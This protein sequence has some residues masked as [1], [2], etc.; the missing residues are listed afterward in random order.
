MPLRA[1]ASPSAPVEETSLTVTR[2]AGNTYYQGVVE[3]FD[4]TTAEFSANSNGVLS[5][6]VKPNGNFS[7]LWKIY[8][9]LPGNGPLREGTYDGVKPYLYVPTGGDLDPYK[10]EVRFS[11]RRSDWEPTDAVVS[12]TI[13]KA[14]RPTLGTFG[15]HA[16]VEL[17]PSPGAPAVR[18]E[19]KYHAELAGPSVNLPPGVY[20]GPDRVAYPNQP[21]V[22]D[23]LVFDD[24]L[25]VDG[26]RQYHWTIVQQGGNY[27]LS[28]SRVAAPT[29]RLLDR[30]AYTFQLEVSDGEYSRKDTIKITVVDVEG[31]WQGFLEV[32]AATDTQGWLQVTGAPAG[33]FTGTL[34][35]LNLRVSFKGTFDAMGAATLP[36]KLGTFDGTLV[37]R[38]GT[39]GGL[40]AELHT[41]NGYFTAG[42]LTITARRGDMGTVPA[43]SF[44]LIFRASSGEADAFS[45]A[46]GRLTYHK[47]RTASLV[48]VLPDGSRASGSSALTK[49]NTVTGLLLTSGSR[50]WLGVDLF[51]SAF[52][53]I[54]LM[55][56]TAHWVRQLG[57]PGQ[58]REYDLDIYGTPSV[59]VSS[60]R[61][62]L[63]GKRTAYHTTLSL[64]AAD[65][66]YSFRTTT[67][68]GGFVTGIKPEDR[69]VFTGAGG[70]I[71]TIYTPSDAVA[72]LSIGSSGVFSGFALVPG[73]DLIRFRG[74]LLRDPGSSGSIGY[75]FG[76]GPHGPW[77]VRLGSSDLF[78]A[79]YP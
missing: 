28:N 72:T 5:I 4:P 79:F 18:L 25:P 76:Q 65:S 48:A 16:T 53:P 66:L 30:G 19:I 52:D 75:G 63:G 45:F 44:A 32:P 27:L 62:P 3:S 73:R 60:A 42:N 35:M 9:A 61:E 77:T 70:F 54:E 68:P 31:K 69:R 10:G 57:K 46:Y 13:H 20:A 59:R 15:V 38:H 78:S 40:L 71:G 43:G 34:R 51:V 74:I 2:D 7:P 8:L 36:L 67:L 58:L 37:L 50:G 29:V 1:D 21:F 39:D 6:E 12:V 14:V 55:Q 56:G 11:A 41:M 64:S 23:P 17:R 24:D 22:F 33:Q 26:V 47:N 49:D